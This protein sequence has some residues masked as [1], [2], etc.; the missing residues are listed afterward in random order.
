MKNVT[1]PNIPKSLK[2]KASRWK[3]ELLDEIEKCGGV[4]RVEARF[5]DRY[6][7]EDVKIALNSM[8]SGLCCYCESRIGVVS[9]GHIEHRKPKRKFPDE[10]FK[11]ENLHFAC[12]QCNNA[13]GDQYDESEPILDAVNDIPINDHLTY[14]MQSRWPIT[15]R[16]GTTE[17][18]ADLNRQELKSARRAILW[19]ALELIGEMKNKPDDPSAR[20]VKQELSSLGEG[21][22]GSLIAYAMETF[23]K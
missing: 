22:Y 11:W 7:K 17:K 3:K 4:K 1:R 12:E 10:T 14:K 6:R 18:H 15:N 8:Y 23:L 19:R 20:V 21:E 9:F 13:K 16:G 5:F 2:R